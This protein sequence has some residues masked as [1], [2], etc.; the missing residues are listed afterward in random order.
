[1][2]LFYIAMVSGG[3]NDKDDID[4]PTSGTMRV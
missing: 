3:L 4:G 1:M 2:S